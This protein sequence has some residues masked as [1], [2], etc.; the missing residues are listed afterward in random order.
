[1]KRVGFIGRML[2][3]LGAL[4]AIGGL[5]SLGGIWELRM[6]SAELT[7]AIRYHSPRIDYS[8]GLRA[9]SWEMIARQ[10][11]SALHAAQHN[12]AAMERDIKAWHTADKRAHEMAD[13][14]MPLLKEDPDGVRQLNRVEAAWAAYEPRAAAFM[15]LVRSGKLDELGPLLDKIDPCIKEMDEAEAALRDTGREKLKQAGERSGLINMAGL[16]VASFAALLFLTVI[17]VAIRLTR[18]AGELLK[19]GILGVYKGANQVASAAASVSETSQAL[20]LGANSRGTVLAGSDTI[21]ASEKVNESAKLNQANAQTAVELVTQTQCTI[22]ETGQALDQTVAAMKEQIVSSAKISHIIKVI[23]EI[24]FQTNL[25]ALNAS[26]EAARAGRAGLGFAVVADE[27]RRL[28]RRS[29]EAAEDTAALIEESIAKSN[30]SGAK[31]DRTARSFQTIAQQSN[32]VK[33]LVNEMC[34]ASQE[35][36]QYVFQFSEAIRSSEANAERR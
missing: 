9:R 4:V 21:A 3:A 35:Q 17:G 25:L 29:A 14:V 15:D 32:R 27:V 22:G 12:Q 36:T 24:A 10:Q 34:T 19:S 7:R 1:M 33:D 8:Q 6:V 31:V 5:H 23:N 30:Q 13:T 18:R 16:W 2:L 20:A 26:V 11:Q 28:A